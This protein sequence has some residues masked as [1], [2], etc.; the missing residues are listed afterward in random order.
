MMSDILFIIDNSCSMGGWQTHVATNFDSF[1]TV[2]QNSGVDFHIA[3]S[4]TDRS[5]FV[6]SIIDTN[7][8]DPIGEFNSQA[9][10]GTYGSGWEMGLDMA[11][12]AL[13]PGGDAAPGSVFER[14]D[15]K[16]SLI[17][18]SDEPDSS[19]SFSNKV[20]YSTYFKSVKLSPSR[21]I[22]HA[23]GGECPS[24]CSFPHTNSYGYTYNSWASCGMAMMMWWLIWA[25]HICHFVIPT[26]D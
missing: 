19:Q 12:Q 14:A 3:L 5:T 6:G 23:V 2:F 24:G 18:V 4:Q 22:A 15:A 17:F 10:V 21:I 7:T 16:M 25:G 8:V 26:G 11:F 1:I 13:Q 20:D 9:Q